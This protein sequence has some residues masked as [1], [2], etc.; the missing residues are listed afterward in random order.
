M[1]LKGALAAALQPAARNA[2][3]ND[4]HKSGIRG[5]GPGAV[6]GAKRPALRGHGRRCG[7]LALNLLLEG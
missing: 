5:R 7:A 1:A 2:A 3:S 4:A 6:Y